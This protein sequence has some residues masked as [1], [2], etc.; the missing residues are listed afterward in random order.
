[1]SRKTLSVDDRL[2]DYLLPLGDGLALARK[3]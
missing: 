2:Y 1:M 3:R